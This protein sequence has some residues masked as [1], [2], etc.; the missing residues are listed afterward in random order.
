MSCLQNADFLL[1]FNKTQCNKSNDVMVKT[2]KHSTP[3]GNCFFFQ[4]PENFV[5]T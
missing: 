4:T 2:L 1:F 5:N 3:E